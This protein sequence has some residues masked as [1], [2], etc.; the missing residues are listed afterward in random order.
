MHPTRAVVTSRV[1]RSI[2]ALALVGVALALSPTTSSAETICGSCGAGGVQF[3]MNVNFPKQPDNFASTEASAI[4]SDDFGIARTGPNNTSPCLDSQGNSQPPLSTFY[5]Q[6]T[7]GGFNVNID[8]VFG[9][10]Y[11]LSTST[12]NDALC[13][14]DYQQAVNDGTDFGGYSGVYG[15]LYALAYNEY[16]PLGSQYSSDITA[17][18]GAQIWVSQ[19][20]TYYENSCL[21]NGDSG[22]TMC[23]YVEV[24][25]EPAVQQ[26]FWGSGA[27]SSTNAGWYAYLLEQ[28]YNAFEGANS[29]LGISAEPLLLASFD[30]GLRNQYWGEDL[31]S[32]PQNIN[33]ADYV[34]GVT[35][36]PYSDQTS[37]NYCH[38]SGFNESDVTN[39]YQDSG[40]E[41]VF[42][43]E[44][45]WNLFDCTPGQQAQDL[46]NFELWAVD[47]ASN[48]GIALVN[49]FAYSEY[50]SANG[51]YDS[52]GSS[53]ST[54]NWWGT[55]YTHNEHVTVS[56]PSGSGTS[57]TV[58][59]TNSQYPW[60]TGTAPTG[61]V[62]FDI[63][64]TSGLIQAGTTVTNIAWSGSSL[65][66]TLSQPLRRN[67]YA[68]YNDSATLTSP[69]P[70]GSTQE[71]WG[72]L[73][74]ANQG[75]FN[76]Y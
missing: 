71:A 33:V 49:T 27:N 73:G 59:S 68:G 19:M 52:T 21:P 28:T 45:G 24:L 2:A 3:G 10:G 35:V 37:T 18:N 17:A 31:W 41:P 13:G 62:G 56:A 15:M 38:A 6:T 14:G 32:N 43:T 22:V 74:Q 7:P 30:G 75:N 44:V 51:S 55:G 9:F 64:D 34:N 47:N 76:C 70:E 65:V 23:P 1:M 50:G 66:L 42:I 54:P 39:A 72:M 58:A 63:T 11:P 20:L 67:I 46:C 57:L 4:A 40:G 36:H 26:N 12:T 60:T 16:H 69:L 53:N 29:P 5:D 8:L 48:Y 61:L 25:N